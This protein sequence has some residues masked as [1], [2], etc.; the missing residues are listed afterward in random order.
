MSYVLDLKVDVHRKNSSESSDSNGAYSKAQSSMVQ[1]H[2]AEICSNTNRLS[3]Q[4]QMKTSESNNDNQRKDNQNKTEIVDDTK[5]DVIVETSSKTDDALSKRHQYKSKR[6]QKFM[7]SL[8]RQISLDSE[9]MG[10][11]FVF[12]GENRGGVQLQ[13]HLSSED[14]NTKTHRHFVLQNLDP[15]QVRNYV[16]FNFLNFARNLYDNG[17]IVIRV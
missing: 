6:K 11:G 10:M 5:Y 15:D 9:K 1:T 2:S 3:S 12:S 13:R 14:Q 16:W 7:N 8:Q 17:T 4:S